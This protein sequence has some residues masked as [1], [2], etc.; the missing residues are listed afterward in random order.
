MNYKA[1]QPRDDD[2]A[3]CDC[4]CRAVNGDLG[5]EEHKTYSGSFRR[6]PHV[7][8]KLGMQCIQ[9]K[10]QPFAAIPGGFRYMG[11]GLSRRTPT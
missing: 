10:E 9:G 6:P 11:T 5:R 4:D 8:P 7:T 2:V 1:G 3:D